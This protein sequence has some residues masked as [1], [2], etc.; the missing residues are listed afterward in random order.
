MRVCPVKSVVDRDASE[1]Q[2]RARGRVIIITVTTHTTYTVFSEYN[3]RNEH[4][5]PQTLS[6]QQDSTDT[7]LGWIIIRRR[8]IYKR[9]RDNI[10]V[11]L[12]QLL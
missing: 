3:L 2:T 7:S 8:K 5:M 1:R 4:A 9:H 11:R 6:I 12:A 10:P